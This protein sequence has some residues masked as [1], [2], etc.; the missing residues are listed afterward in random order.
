MKR[1]FAVLALGLCLSATAC[2]LYQ[3]IPQGNGV[4]ERGN[5]DGD[6]RGGADLGAPDHAAD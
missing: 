3:L 5:S 2:D 1:L 6:N 4:M